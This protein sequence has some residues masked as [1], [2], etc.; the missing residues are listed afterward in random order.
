MVHCD[1][2]ITGAFPPRHHQRGGRA[3]TSRRVGSPPPQP[4]CRCWRPPCTHHHSGPARGSM[5][6]WCLLGINAT[7]PPHKQ[8]GGSSPPGPPRP[9]GGG[10]LGRNQNNPPPLQ[11]TTRKH[12]PGDGI[13]PPGERH[14]RDGSGNDD[15]NNSTV[16]CEGHGSDGYTIA[17]IDKSGNV[18]STGSNDGPERRHS[19]RVAFRMVTTSPGGGGVGGGVAEDGTAYGCS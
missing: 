18:W 16:H 17:A 1:G 14:R 7:G 3:R 11:T 6:D 19:R 4:W 8:P 12:R 2:T 9:P 10:H 13:L 15:D 5:R